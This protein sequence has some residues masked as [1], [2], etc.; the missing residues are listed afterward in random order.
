MRIRFAGVSKSFGDVRALCDLD[1]LIHGGELLVLVG[2]SGCGKSTALRVLAGLERPTSGRVLIGDRDVTDLPPHRRDIAMV[3]Q[4][5]ALYPHM[6]ARDNILFGPRVRREPAAAVRDRVE[7]VVRQ[8]GLAGVLDRYPD[9][10]SG[11]QRQR[12][13]LARAMVRVPAAYLMDE[14]LSDLDAQLRLQARTEIVEL[15]RAIGATMIYVTHEQAEAMTM[16]DRIAVLADGRLQQVG[17]PTE[18]YDEPANVTVAGFLGSPP[19]NLVPGG[20]ILG[21]DPDTVLG[22]R[23]ED[24]LVHAEP[25]PGRFPAQVSVVESLG[26]ETVL[27]LVCTDGTRVAARTPPRIPYRPGCS[28][29]LSVAAGRRHVFGRTDGRRRETGP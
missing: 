14:P 7:E 21:G 18:V 10:L 8:L 9:Q 6:T 24:L 28:L 26:S 27:S 19:M 29:H 15:H 17:T 2:P 4:D 20:G 3:F 25:G 22:V 16:G 23:P 1:L 13:A 5:L 11:G 12:V